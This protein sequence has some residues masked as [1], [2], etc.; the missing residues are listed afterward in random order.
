VRGPR[1]GH[2]N[3]EYGHTLLVRVLLIED[4]EPLAR[5]MAKGLREANYA[6]DVTA[7]GAEGLALAEAGSYDGVLLDLMVPKMDGLAILERLRARGS[8]TGVLVVTARDQVSDR[9]AGL[10]LGA[11][12]YLVKPFAFEELLARLRAVIRRRYLKPSNLVRIHDLEVDAGGRSVRRAG[13]T[14]P[15]SALEYALLEYLAVRRGQVVT[16]SEIL[17]H[18]Y[19]LAKEP[20]SN[21]VDVYVGY[22]RKKI[23]DGHPVKLLRTHRGLGYSL[24]EPA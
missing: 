14:I 10:D 22:L 12:D 1:S 5:S 6:V 3:A 11:D 23:D 21:V 19:D 18:V 15:L 20:T 24:E 13:K 17:E 7:D 8:T 16:R 9:V 2:L 4:F